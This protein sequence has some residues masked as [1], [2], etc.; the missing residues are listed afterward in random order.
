MYFFGMGYIS[1]MMEEYDADM[2]GVFGPFLQR[3][4][5]EAQ[6]LWLTVHFHKACKSH[7]GT[8]IIDS[9]FV[10]YHSN[11]ITVE[12]CLDKCTTHAR[13]VKTSSIHV[14]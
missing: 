3:E 8:L 6:S 4:K 10:P 7:N 13:F 5:A 1:V 14:H 2:T 9:P 11:Q 12:N